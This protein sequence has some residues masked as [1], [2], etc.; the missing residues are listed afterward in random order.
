MKAE[1][2]SDNNEVKAPEYI[3][4]NFGPSDRVAILV[5]DSRRTEAT[6]RITTAEN[7][8]TP[9]FQVWLRHKNLTSDAQYLL[10]HL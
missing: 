2:V 4:E 8:A 7:A 5:R 10:F 1:P 9:D 3:R 6:Q